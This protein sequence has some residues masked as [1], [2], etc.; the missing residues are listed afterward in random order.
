MSCL[1]KWGLIVP[2]K[3]TNPSP[4]LARAKSLACSSVSNILVSRG[5]RLFGN[6]PRLFSSKVTYQVGDMF[7]A[8]PGK[9]LTVTLANYGVTP[10]PQPSIVS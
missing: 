4:S 8:A 3:T 6:T 9:I 1:G 2:A 10:N 5:L 7:Q